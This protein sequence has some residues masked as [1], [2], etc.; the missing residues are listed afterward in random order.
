VDAQKVHELD[1]DVVAVGREE[2]DSP[3]CCDGIA[4]YGTEVRHR[5]GLS[6]TYFGGEVGYAGG[7]AHPHNILYVNV[8]AEEPFLVVVYI[9]E[10]EEAIAVL[11]E[12]IKEGRILTHGRIGVGRIVG[13]TFIVAGQQDDAT[14]KESLQFRATTDIGFFLEH[15]CEIFLQRYK[16]NT[17]PTNDSDFFSNFAR[18]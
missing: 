18:S 10:T 11:T 12:I 8:I 7:I 6:D 5:G 1:L 14:A 16:E 2:V 3:V 4:T 9:N 15:I 13:R 17:E